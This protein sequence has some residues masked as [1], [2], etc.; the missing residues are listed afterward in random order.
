MSTD[1]S[2]ITCKCFVIVP[3]FMS[4]FV[5]YCGYRRGIQAIASHNN[6]CTIEARFPS[7]IILSACSVSAACYL[8]AMCLAVVVPEQAAY[9]G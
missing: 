2:H 6:A 5:A 8:L 4:D 7:Q 3:E 1:T 9:R